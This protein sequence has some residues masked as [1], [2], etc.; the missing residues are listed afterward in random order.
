[1]NLSDQLG[2][3]Y[4]KNDIERLGNV[5]FDVKEK[6]DE[7]N[8][9]IICELLL[10]VDKLVSH[11]QELPHLFTFNIVTTMINASDRVKDDLDHIV[12]NYNS[13]YVNEYDFEDEDDEVT[14]ITNG[15]CKLYF[16]DETN[17]LFV[18]GDTHSLIGLIGPTFSNTQGCKN[19]QSALNVSYAKHIKK[20]SDYIKD[21][22]D[23]QWVKINE[24]VFHPVMIRP[25]EP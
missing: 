6:I 1:M 25:W 16:K 9:R 23:Y 14:I 2:E 17:I 8:Y 5:L 4:G 13:D 12:D 7:K 22:I 18:M 24:T 10:K 11:K 15:Y 21:N 3:D 20:V 19:Y